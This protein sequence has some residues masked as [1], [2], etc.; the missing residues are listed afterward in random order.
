[1]GAERDGC[2]SIDDG[3]KKLA[4]SAVGTETNAI[5]TIRGK[6]TNDA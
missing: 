4:T 2:N 3:A 6:E 1:M 5:A